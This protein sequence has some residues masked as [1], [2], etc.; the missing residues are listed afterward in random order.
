MT[1]LKIIQVGSGGWGKSWLKFLSESEDWELAGLV[2]RGGKNL[3]QAKSQW[4]LQDDLCFND[5]DEALATSAD[6]VLVTVPHNLHVPV[7]RKASEAGKHV[8][9]EKPFSDDFQAA[10]D[11]VSFAES[12]ELQLAV[13]QNFRYRLGLWQMKALSEPLEPVDS[14]RIELF[15]PQ[16]RLPDWRADQ[17]STLALEIM[18][19][20]VDMTRFLLGAKAERVFCKAWNPSWS[21]S[22]GP[23]NISAIIEFDTGAVLSYLGSWAARGK[24]SGWEGQWRVQFENGVTTWE[25][26]DPETENAD[27]ETISPPVVN[28]FPGHD[29]DGLLIDFAQAIRQKTPFPTNGKDNLQSLAIIF[30]AIASFQENRPV[31]INELLSE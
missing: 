4:Q 12:T 22:K 24:Q 9:C 8:L 14:L 30:A 31:A 7:A 17:V 27:I 28:D 18:I 3:E 19:H 20:H 21:E 23:A 5:L 11:L 26:G 16:G 13:S 1:P 25:G 2:S 6:T 10:V 15:Q 29:R